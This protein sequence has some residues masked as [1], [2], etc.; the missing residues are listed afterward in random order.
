MLTTVIVECAQY[1]NRPDQIKALTSKGIIPIEHDIKRM[2]EEG[3]EITFEEQ[4]G[5]AAA[6]RFSKRVLCFSFNRS[7][8]A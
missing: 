6:F 3:Q 1:Q 2:S 5:R 4:V 7:G 8:P